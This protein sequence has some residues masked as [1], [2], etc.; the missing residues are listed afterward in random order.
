MGGQ[1]LESSIEMAGHPY[2]SDFTS[3]EHTLN[4]EQFGKFFSHTVNF[5][6]DQSNMLEGLY[7]ESH[8]IWTTLMTEH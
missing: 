7:F 2:N 5:L 6:V 1:I 8:E 4:I 3:V